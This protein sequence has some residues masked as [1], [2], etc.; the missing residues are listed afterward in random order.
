MRLFYEYVAL[1]FGG[2]YA[3]FW[4]EQGNDLA[5]NNLNLNIFITRG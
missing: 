3:L 4:E 5:Q 1:V 2:V